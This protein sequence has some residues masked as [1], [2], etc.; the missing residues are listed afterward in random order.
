MK[1]SKQRVAA[2]GILGL[3]VLALGADRVVLGTSVSGPATAGA[4]E[5]PIAAEAPA[6]APLADA[7][8]DKQTPR[9]ATKVD[10]ESVASRLRPDA[11]SSDAAALNSVNADDAFVVPAAWLPKVVAVSGA[12]T[13]ATTKVPDAVTNFKATITSIFGTQAAPVVRVA[14]AGGAPMTVKLGER[15]GELEL[16]RVNVRELTAVFGVDGFEKTL[17]LGVSNLQ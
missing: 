8:A 14:V 2:V 1:L 9:H 4:A 3:A 11:A 17:S 16:L 6:A 7:A 13:T 5:V 15:V 10:V 12:E